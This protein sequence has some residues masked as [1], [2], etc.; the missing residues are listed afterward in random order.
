MLTGVRALGS[1]T[2]AALAAGFLV[3]PFTH[4]H[5]SAAAREHVEQDHSG[6]LALHFHVGS[7]RDA[8]SLEALEESAL[9][10]DWFVLEEPD[11]FA[12]I[13]EPVVVPLSPELAAQSIAWPP[14]PQPEYHPPGLASRSPRG[15]PA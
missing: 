9:Q 10:L 11:G 8:P 14:G 4:V 1:I 6:S 3:A 7:D 2:A 12:W 15:P 13:A 5:D